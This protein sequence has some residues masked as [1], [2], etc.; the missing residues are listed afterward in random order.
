MQRIGHGKHLY[1]IG[2]FDTRHQLRAGR[3]EAEGNTR[4]Q[5]CANV[6]KYFEAAAKARGEKNFI[7]VADCNMVG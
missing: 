3:V 6:R 2:L 4:T 1:E 5:A 7:T